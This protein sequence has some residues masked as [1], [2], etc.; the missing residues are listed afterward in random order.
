MNKYNKIY[1]SNEMRF[2][3]YTE[4]SIG[5]PANAFLLLFHVL[6]YFLQHRLKP[7][8][9]TIGLLALIHL[10]MLMI[11]VSQAMDMF[12]S[13]GSWDDVTCKAVFFSY[14]VLRALSLYTSCLLCVL[15]AITLSP[16]SSWLAKYKQAFSQRIL[17]SLFVLCL[18]SMSI[19]SHLIISITATTNRTSHSRMYATKSCSVLPMSFFLMQTF[20]TM[21]ILREVIQ[22]GIMALSSGYMVILLCRHR[23]KSQ[24]LR[25]T[26]LSPRASPEQR[27]TQTILVLM[28]FFMVICILDCIFSASRLMLN[29][30]P[31]IYCIHIIVSNNYATVSPCV[32]LCN[33]KRIITFVKSIRGRT[34]DVKLFNERQ[35]SK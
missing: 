33:E 28:S 20:S 19:S 21:A 7:T 1:E 35:F 11:V 17:C 29:D 25:D 27:A 16:R 15:Q 22:V 32:F 26:S 4:I 2:I 13:Q 14:R 23:R 3:Y 30:D 18:F 34:I 9:M 6:N 12:G 31:I 10:V 8:D 24:H 5:V